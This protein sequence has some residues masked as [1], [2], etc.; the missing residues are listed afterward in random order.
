MKRKP[1]ILHPS[2]VRSATLEG[3][4]F[5]R[6]TDDLAAMA[7]YLMALKLPF[8]I[9]E[10]PVLREA[11]LH[12]AEQMTQIAMA[13]IPRGDS[14]ASMPQAVNCNCLLLHST[15]FPERPNVGASRK[16]RMM[17]GSWRAKVT[18]TSRFATTA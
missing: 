4:L 1:L 6:D 8:V 3:T 17:A 5:E 12:L 11:L 16:T 18:P 15:R 7:R 2:S 9:H 14:T 10:P 13:H